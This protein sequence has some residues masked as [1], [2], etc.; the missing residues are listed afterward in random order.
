M[1][2]T[3]RKVKRDAVL[4]VDKKEVGQGRGSANR[5]RDL[6]K[7]SLQEEPRGAA[8]MAPQRS[9]AATGEGV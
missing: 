4:M 3:I 8:E 6:G 5:G 1:R 7:G 9:A 2:P